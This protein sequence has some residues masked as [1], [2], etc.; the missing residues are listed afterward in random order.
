MRLHASA[1]V[2]D[3]RL[4]QLLANT[5]PKL[6]VVLVQQTLLIAHQHCFI[7]TYRRQSMDGI[8]DKVC[9]F[10]E[11]YVPSL[12][13]SKGMDTSTDCHGELMFVEAH[14][15]SNTPHIFGEEDVTGDL[16]RQMRGDEFGCNAKDAMEH[17][18]QS[19]VDTL[20]PGLDDMCKAT[21]PSCV[22]PVVLGVYW[23]TVS[24]HRYGVSIR[25]HCSLFA[26][27]FAS[28][29]TPKLLEVLGACDGGA[30]RVLCKA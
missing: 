20:A 9:W 23:L 17:A 7:T 19:M 8:S 18:L 15:G 22:G 10:E 1:V 13:A 14:P 28:D 30:A 29:A 2:S 16:V 5:C 3:R 25:P 21:A 6:Y 24:L 12:L 26:H 11:H 27:K 4:E